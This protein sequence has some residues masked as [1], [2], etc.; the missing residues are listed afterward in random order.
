MAIN[1][2]YLDRRTY[3]RYIDKGLV[4]DS[5]FNSHLKAL[6][7]ETANAQWVEMDLHDA[8]MG[9][10]DLDGDTDGEGQP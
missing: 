4:K 8:E 2:R 9:D 6:P 1:S 5:E 10:G 3:D 7:D